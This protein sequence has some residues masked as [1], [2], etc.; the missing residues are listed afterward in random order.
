MNGTF[1][2]RSTIVFLMFFSAIGGAI[3]AEPDV[4]LFSKAATE[5]RKSNPRVSETLLVEDRRVITSTYPVIYKKMISKGF[6]E[7]EIGMAVAASWTDFRSPEKSLTGLDASIFINTT[8]KYGKL[9]IESVP[10]EAF[11]VI[12]GKLQDEKTNVT[13]WFAPKKYRIVLSKDGYFPEEELRDIKEGNNIP[14]RKTL[15]LLPKKMGPN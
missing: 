2:N 8:V 6:S 12:D 3:A 15:K 7:K 10:V 11:I 1:I 14:L 13:K 5:I 4:Y 9:Q